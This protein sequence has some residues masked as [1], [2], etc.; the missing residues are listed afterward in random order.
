M[1]RTP[2][3]GAAKADAHIDSVPLAQ[4]FARGQTPKAYGIPVATKP[5]VSLTL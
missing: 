5:T 3:T 4:P 2:P 1:V